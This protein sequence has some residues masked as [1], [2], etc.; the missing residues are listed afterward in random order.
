MSASVLT[1]ATAKIVDVE[2][3]LE[4]LKKE[5]E[6]LEQ[7]CPSDERPAGVGDK[8]KHLRMMEISLQ[9][10]VV[11]LMKYRNI[12]LTTVDQLLIGLHGPQYLIAISCGAEPALSLLHWGYKN[13]RIAS[14]SSMSHKKQYDGDC[15]LVSL[16]LSTFCAIATAKVHDVTSGVT[17]PARD[18]MLVRS[19]AAAV[20]ADP[21]GNKISLSA[22]AELNAKFQQVLGWGVVNVVNA[23]IRQKQPNWK[24]LSFHAHASPS[25]GP[26]WPD[27]L[28]KQ[29]G[30]DETVVSDVCGGEGKMPRVMCHAVENLISM[31]GAV[32][33]ALMQACSY[34]QEKKWRFTFITY[35]QYTFFVWRVAQDRYAV[36]DG[37][38]ND[39]ATYSLYTREVLAYIIWMSLESPWG[40]QLLPGSL[41]SLEMELQKRSVERV[42]HGKPK[43][44]PCQEHLG[45]VQPA[46]G[47]ARTLSRTLSSKQQQQTPA[48]AL[49]D[50]IRQ[51]D[52]PSPWAPA[53]DVPE[54]PLA[55]L[56]LSST[57]L[58]A[59]QCGP[60]MQG[61]LR[62]APVA[63]KAMDACDSPD[64]VELLRHE[65]QI[66]DILRD[67]QGLFLPTLHGSGYWRGQSF[68]LATSVVVGKPISSCISGKDEAAAQAVAQAARQALQAIHQRGVAHGDVRADNILVQD[69]GNTPQVIII[70]FGHAYLDP[71][72]EQCERELAELTQVFHELQ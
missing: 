30:A 24:E 20:E 18:A 25:V 15:E 69:C 35:Y 44:Q 21:A 70:D 14:I 17:I 48:A 6:R 2:E 33:D 47:S 53:E 63:V 19:S 27:F 45:Q 61:W 9:E 12:L 67:L 68:V 64:G 34:C 29:R 39:A 65:A 43:I 58:G 54:L 8:L 50:A 71:T 38:V 57:C 16:D 52:Q 11:E 1:E 49:Q 37:L 13:L 51:R 26:G 59:G 72:P 55:S 32:A 60:V 23:C 66:Y 10:K 4:G 3:E 31:D 22:E 40:S 46:Q 36:T 42:L 56:Q 7:P 62:G 28:I 5:I 41:Q